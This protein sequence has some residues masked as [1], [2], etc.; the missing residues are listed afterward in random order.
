[1]RHTAELFERRRKAEADLA[2]ARY[3]KPLG[4]GFHRVRLADETE[5]TVG[6]GQGSTTYAPGQTVSI[7]TYSGSRDR[8]IATG[9]APGRR[10]GSLAP[11]TLIVE[12][13]QQPPALLGVYP[14]TYEAGVETT[15]YV[16]GYRLGGADF[17]YY[18]LD[19]QGEEVVDERAVIFGECWLPNLGFQFSSDPVVGVAAVTTPLATW[20]ITGNVG[21]DT[22]TVDEIDGSGDTLEAGNAFLA[23]IWIDT[24]AETVGLAK[25][26]QGVD[27]ESLMNPPD[28]PSGDSAIPWVSIIRRPGDL[29]ASGYFVIPPYGTVRSIT[30]ALGGQEHVFCWLYADPDLIETAVALDLRA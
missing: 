30:E 26:P 28:L 17:Y 24:E 21:A 6:A 10:G 18:T 23:V 7:A 22:I 16:W 27:G 4:R 14:L 15:G 11:N 19:D 1:M 12:T 13:M 2:P 3:V 20:A 25:G 5:Y 29:D 9:P 8:Q